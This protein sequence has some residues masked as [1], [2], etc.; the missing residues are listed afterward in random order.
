MKKIYCEAN[1]PLKWFIG[2]IIRVSAD[3]AKLVHRV[4]TEWGRNAFL[5]EI[6]QC[7]L[8]LIN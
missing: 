6:G 3:Q 8:G 5:R 1:K 7:I 2:E 4:E